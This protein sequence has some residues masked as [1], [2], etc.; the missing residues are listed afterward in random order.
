M[1]DQSLP[2][3]ARARV[4]GLLEKA[5]SP[6]AEVLATDRGSAGWDAEIRRAG[7][8]P[9]CVKLRPWEAAAEPSAAMGDVWVLTR[10]GRDDLQRLR[11][12]GLNFVALNG[13]VRVVHD[14]L[15]VDR[16]GLARRRSP[17][18]VFKRYDPFAD[19]NSRVTRTLLAHPGRV[20]GVREL[21]AGAGVALGTASQVLGSLSRSGTVRVERSGRSARVSLDDPARLLRRWLAAY[22]WERNERVAFH[23][24]VGDLPRFLRRLPELLKDTRWALTLHAGASLIAPH[25]TWERVHAYVAVPTAADLARVGVAQGW[26]PAEEGQVVLMKPFYRTSVWDGVK[27]AGPLP[28]VSEL[29][30]V[31]DL[32][33]YPLRGREQAEHLLGTTL[34]I[35]E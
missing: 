25:A 22:T 5:V 30:L 18:G 11:S 35:E 28:V 31:L 8:A 2:E 17:P 21:A 3:T 19:R 34:H 23:A 32:W 13:S 6:A 16:T 15:L 9:I 26:T 12:R 24:P 7:V 4:L 14:W 20:W 29:Q 33:H 10:P 1:N 27:L